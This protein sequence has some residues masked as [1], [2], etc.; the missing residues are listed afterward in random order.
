VRRIGVGRR[1]GAADGERRRENGPPE[2]PAIVD[3]QRISRAGK[4]ME[5]A[6]EFARPGSFSPDASEEA[7][8]GIEDSQLEPARI[9]DDQAMIPEPAGRDNT[10]KFMT[11]RHVILGQP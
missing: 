1:Q 10:G 8:G 6:H 4:N 11:R 9:R 7:S 2:I 3:G 5:G